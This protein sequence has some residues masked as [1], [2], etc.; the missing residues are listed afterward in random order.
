MPLTDEKQARRR[1]QFAQANHSLHLEGMNMTPE[2]LEL[3]G[4][5]ISGR[6]SYDDLV[7]HIKEKFCG[8][9]VRR[10]TDE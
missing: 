5:V 10:A 2:D 1:E 6:W 4:N 3:Q 7:E 9:D 8:P